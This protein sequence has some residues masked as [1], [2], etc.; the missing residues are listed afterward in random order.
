[1]RSEMKLRVKPTLRFDSA[2]LEVWLGVCCPGSM[3]VGYDRAC[4]ACTQLQSALA[5]YLGSTSTVRMD[6]NVKYFCECAT[7]QLSRARP[8]TIKSVSAPHDFGASYM[9]SDR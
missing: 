5:N 2:N 6:Q 1:M 4:D 8:P 3:H 7:K 9:H